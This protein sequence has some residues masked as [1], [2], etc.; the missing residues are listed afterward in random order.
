[1][2]KPVLQLLVLN[3]F[4]IYRQ[5]QIEEALLRTDENNWCI[6]NNGTDPA[7]VMGISGAPEELLSAVF[8]RTAPLPLIRR[9]SGGG[10]V[11]VDQGT[12]FSTLICN[13]QEIE[14]SCFPE[15]VLQWTK[16]L[17]EN[18]FQ[19]PDFRVRENDYAIGD[20]KCGGNAQYF[21]KDRWLHHT[22][23]LWDYNPEHMEYLLLPKRTPKY[24]LKRSHGEFLYRLCHHIPEKN[25]IVSRICQSLSEKFIIQEQTLEYAEKAL[26]RPHRK[27][28]TLHN[29]L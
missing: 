2:T 11:V 22:S 20:Y 27:A 25:E 10:T 21:R 15:Q 6:L 12:I 13:S 4:P 5:L 18:A 24:R 19:H 23:F 3:H 7:I 9:F 17:Y 8:M 28:T 14:V 1:M 26:L 16:P 29:M